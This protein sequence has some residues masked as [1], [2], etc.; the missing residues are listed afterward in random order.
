M[1]RTWTDHH[2]FDRHTGFQRHA[3]QFAQHLA[4][5]LA[6]L[7]RARK[8]IPGQAVAE[9]ASQAL[10]QQIGGRSA[11]SDAAHAAEQTRL[12]DV[13][14]RA[15]GHIDHRHLR[16]GEVLE[17][18]LVKS[19]FQQVG[20]GALGRHAAQVFLHGRAA[21]RTRRNWHSTAPVGHGQREQFMTVQPAELAAGQDGVELDAGHLPQ[22]TGRGLAHPQLGRLLVALLQHE[23]LAVRGPGEAVERAV[24]GQLDD[25]LGRVCA[26]QRAQ[27]QP[28]DG[29]DVLR[30]ARGGVKADPGQFQYRPRQLVDAWH[31]AHLQGGQGLPVG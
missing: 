4:I 31:A 19:V 20:V 21:R 14:A 5:A 1:K 11:V 6:Q 26:Q 23:T 29:R 3:G 18:R 2:T 8:V 25:A 16:A 7:H 17:L 28:Q 15:G 30:A 12:A 27:T 22:A 9:W 10:G 24:V 13:L